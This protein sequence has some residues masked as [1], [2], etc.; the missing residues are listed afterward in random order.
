MPFYQR[1]KVTIPLMI[2]TSFLTWLVYLWAV[3]SYRPSLKKTQALT[4]VADEVYSIMLQN[5]LD[6]IQIKDG[7]VWPE[8]LRN[9]KFDALSADIDSISRKIERAVFSYIC[10]E[11][12]YFTAYFY[13]NLPA[14]FV[15]EPY[16]Y[17][18]YNP[19]GHLH[20]TSEYQTNSR[21]TEY[22]QFNRLGWD[23]E[24]VSSISEARKDRR[25]SGYFFC[26][27]LKQISWH[28]CR[29]EIK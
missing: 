2:L 6:S 21:L 14:E 16:R 15:R 13:F 8:T 4:A 17:L 9:E 3:E 10:E 22:S 1:K 19:D 5:D 23:E 7:L 11:K 18:Q 25:R 12:C 26:E 27:P 20:Y 24:F 29:G 28:F